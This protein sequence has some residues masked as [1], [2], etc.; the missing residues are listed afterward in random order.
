[1]KIYEIA[2]YKLVEVKLTESEMEMVEAIPEPGNKNA[3]GNHK[4]FIQRPDGTSTFYHTDGDMPFSKAKQ[5]AQKLSQGGTV[6][7]ATMNPGGS[8]SSD[9]EMFSPDPPEIDTT[10]DFE[11]KRAGIGKADEP[12]KSLPGAFK[13]GLKDR[14]DAFL[15][16]EEHV[17]R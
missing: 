7:Y 1:M 4:F 9:H 15:S 10:H 3:M 6:E 12:V 8:L 11:R 14:L 2:Q 5:M 17:S 16:G 13:K